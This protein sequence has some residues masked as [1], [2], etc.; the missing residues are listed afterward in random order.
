MKKSIFIAVLGVTAV[1]A[2][3]SYGQ[4]FVAFSSYIANGGSGALTSTFG[5]ATPLGVGYT[6]YLYYALGTVSD[7]VNESLVSSIT[8]PISGAFTLL[9]GSGTAYDNSGNAIGAAGLG[10]FDGATLTIPSYSGGAI[11]W[12]ILA[13]NGSGSVVGRSGSFTDSSIAG[14]DVPVGVIGDNTTGG[15]PSFLVAPVPEP[16]TLALAGLGGLAS[17]VALRRK[18][19]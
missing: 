16:T 8:S 13:S 10:Y 6:A 5:T 19:A 9:A 4:G 3:S 11:S 17:L 12:E 15:F 7:P 2:T 14:P 1:A 18:Q